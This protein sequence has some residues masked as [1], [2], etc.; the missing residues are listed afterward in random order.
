MRRRTLQS[1][2]IR[3]MLLAA[4]LLVIGPAACASPGSYST[5]PRADSGPCPFYKVGE[6]RGVTGQEVQRAMR[7]MGGD[8][9]RSRPDSPGGNPDGITLYSAEIFRYESPRCRRGR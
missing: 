6:V 5:Q 2:P 9:V 3:G 4:V 8:F 7:R 1:I